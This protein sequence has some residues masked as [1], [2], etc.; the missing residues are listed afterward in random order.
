VVLVAV[1]AFASPSYA[2]DP[3]AEE[4]A[5]VS[6]GEA[7]PVAKATAEVAESTG[8]AA[9]T[10]ALDASESAVATGAGLE[11]GAT[12][13]ASEGAD[14]ANPVADSAETEMEEASDAEVGG[15]VAEETVE[16]AEDDAQDGFEDDDTDAYEDGY[17]IVEFT[18]EDYV[19]ADSWVPSIVFSVVV[20]EEDTEI[21]VDSRPLEFSFDRKEVRTL[22]SLRFGG[23]LMTPTFDELPIKPR[24]FLS[25]GVL[26]STP[27]NG[28]SHSN[29]DTTSVDDYRGINLPQLIRA[30]DAV[31]FSN[32]PLSREIDEFEGRGTYVQGRRRH[33]SW[34]AGL[35]GVVTLPRNGFTIRVRPS[36]EYIGE[37]FQ[38]RGEYSL[39]SDVD[40]DRPRFLIHEIDL[41]DKEIQHNIGPG[42]ELEFV[43]HIDGNFTL[44]F[45]AQTRF[46][47]IVG[48][49][50]MRLEG[51]DSQGLDAEFRFKRS[52]FNFRGGLGFRL[53]FR[54]T[55][56]KL[57]L[58]DD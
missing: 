20:H 22:A 53:G 7:E 27:G 28:L 26:W 25:G 38:I 18:D 31:E 54:S 49:T 45:F 8:A 10:A 2:E 32:G 39:L 12:V 5:E 34:Y 19:L 14:E 13:L 42:L 41:S 35:G 46:M 3:A 1:L 36:L 56:F 23:E 43:N 55:A 52:R 37:E 17:A 51:V 48:D 57:G 11:A 15:V 9:E 24:F 4:I 33:N 44:S 29:H 50:E 30:F 47:W 6:E 21:E 16:A 58:F 40:P